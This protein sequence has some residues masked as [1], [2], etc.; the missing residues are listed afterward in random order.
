MKYL[1]IIFLFIGFLYADNNCSSFF[2]CESN[3]RP[4]KNIATNLQCTLP[5]L[6]SAKID[7]IDVFDTSGELLKTY[8]GTGETVCDVLVWMREGAAK[9]SYSLRFA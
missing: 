8:F 1:L 3:A 6:P 5:S 4:P 9:T 7:A 2:N